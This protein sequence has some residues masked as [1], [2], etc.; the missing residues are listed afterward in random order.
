MSKADSTDKRLNKMSP[1][2]KNFPQ[3]TGLLTG[4]REQIDA[5]DAEIID[6]EASF[7]DSK[8]DNVREWM[9]VLLGGLLECSATGAVVATSGRTIIDCVPTE[10]TQPG[11]PRAHYSG[12]SQVEL[13]VAEAERTIRK[14]STIGEAGISFGS[15][16]GVSFISDVAGETSQL[17]SGSGVGNVHGNPPSTLSLPIQPTP[18]QPI[19]P[20]PV[21][22]MPVQPIQPIPIQ[23]IQPI[24]VQPI[25][26]QSMPVQP[27]QQMPV[28]P[29]Q[30]TPFQPIQPYPSL[31]LPN[32]RPSNPHPVQPIQPYPSLTLPNNHPSNPHE[33]N[34][35]GEYNPWSPPPTYT[36]GQ[37]SHLS[38]FDEPS[39]PAG[40][41]VLSPSHPPRPLGLTRDV[42][43]LAS[44]SSSS[45]IRPT[46][47]HQSAQERI[48][49]E[50]Q[51]MLDAEIAKHLQEEDGDGD[52][53]T[54]EMQEAEWY[55]TGTLDFCVGN[56]TD[57]SQDV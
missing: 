54:D 37:W 4:L 20:I 41:S 5:L 32:N 11:L 57:A 51:I 10:P 9:G 23:P 49:I 53:Y 29:I 6:E 8:R 45:A 34:D 40:P 2:D 28:Q 15:E 16:A 18:V 17:P 33:V 31:T 56:L 21:Q 35:F 43:G 42:H 26:V 12:H 36:P 39:N 44:S 3:Q 25:P 46:S 22:P 14:I 27:I 50:E 24:P 19:Q 7:Y 52:I 13:I 55:V 48:V 38:Q 47:T 30:P 1:G